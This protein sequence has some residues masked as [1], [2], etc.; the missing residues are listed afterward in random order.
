MEFFALRQT[1]CL[2]RLT[3]LEREVKEEG[4][5]K[6]IHLARTK[7]PQGSNFRVMEDK[8]V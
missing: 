4:R 8:L 2:V 6:R 7:A 5:V 1:F 3:S